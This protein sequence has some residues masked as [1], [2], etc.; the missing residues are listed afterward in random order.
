[1]SYQSIV[2]RNIAVFFDSWFHLIVS[3]NQ[4]LFILSQYLFARNKDLFYAYWS[5]YA[6]HYPLEFWITFF[7]EQLWQAGIFI[8]KAEKGQFIQAKR[9]AYRLPFTF[10]NKDW[11][12][13]KFTY[14]QRMHDRIYSIDYVNKNTKDTLY[15]LELWIHTF[16][17]NS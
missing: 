9:S 2:G 8:Y 13:Y 12:A 7:S 4:S 1:M 10:I 15:A 16:M 14:I 17:H 5:R 3:E 6:S 11:K